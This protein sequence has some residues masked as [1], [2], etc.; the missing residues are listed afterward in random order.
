MDLPCFVEI[1]TGEHCKSMCMIDCVIFHRIVLN[2]AIHILTTCIFLRQGERKRERNEIEV[3]LSSSTDTKIIAKKSVTSNRAAAKIEDG[4]S[5]HWLPVDFMNRV[6]TIC[7][8]SK[9]SSHDKNAGVR[10]FGTKTP[11][12]CA[13]RGI[14]NI[15]SK[16]WWI[17]FHLWCARCPLKGRPE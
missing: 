13:C 9:A 7:C 3:G 10:L 12:L 2:F 6:V 8:Y 14:I 4:R 17:L 11:T 16:I 15:T 5:C 1:R